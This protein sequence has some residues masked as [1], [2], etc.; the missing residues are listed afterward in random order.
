MSR[1]FFYFLLPS[2]RACKCTRTQ[3]L[4]FYSFMISSLAQFSFSVF[5]FSSTIKRL[6]KQI[7]NKSYINLFSKWNLVVRQFTFLVISFLSFVFVIICL[8]FS[9]FSIFLHPDKENMFTFQAQYVCLFLFFCCASSFLL[10]LVVLL[11]L[12]FVGWDDSL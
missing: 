6:I 12:R 1:I 3:L 4:H 2:A 5:F 11:H 8:F 10:I 7:Q 9:F